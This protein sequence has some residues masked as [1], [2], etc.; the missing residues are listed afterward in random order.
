MKAYIFVWCISNM[1]LEIYNIKLELNNEV[2][3]LKRNIKSW[4][5]TTEQKYINHTW[6]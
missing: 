4:Q 3:E 6:R 5:Q 2:Q 1:I